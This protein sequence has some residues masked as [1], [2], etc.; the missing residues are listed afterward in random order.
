MALGRFPTRVERVDG[1]LPPAVELWVKRED[2]SGTLYGG[3]KVRKLEFLFG[4]ARARG[5]TR[6]ETFGGWGAHHVLATALY[7][8]QAGFRVG[9]TLVPQPLDGHV[10]QV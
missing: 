5:C 3:N 7:G 2:E 10:R 1:I 9:A 8:A 4:D 6:L